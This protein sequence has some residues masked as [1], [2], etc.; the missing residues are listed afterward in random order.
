MNYLMIDTAEG[1]RALLFANGVYLYDENSVNAGSEILWPMLDGLL[2]RGGIKLTDVDVFGA[3]IG[4]G[5][6]TGLRIGLATIKTFCYATGKKCFGVNNLRLNSYN[7]D[8]GRV[9]SVAD[10]GNH[11]CYLAR[12]DG[13]KEIDSAKCMTLDDAKKFIADNPD[14]A[15]STDMKLSSVFAG[16][17]G[18]GERELKIAAEKFI[19]LAAHER[20]LLPLYVRKPQPER[21]DGDL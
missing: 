17:S 10:A 3:S 2:R 21:K 8:S 18:V 11:V 15:V 9:I 6:F 4:P 14:Y 16:K 20:E 5:S 7:N 12:Y 13:D 1:T 19:S